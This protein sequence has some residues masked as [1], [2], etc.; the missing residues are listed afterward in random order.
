MLIL[1]FIPNLTH[2]LLGG[3][4]TVI[5][6]HSF[7]FFP[8]PTLADRCRWPRSL[9]SPVSYLFP[10]A[11][12]DRVTGSPTFL[13][14]PSNVNPPPSEYLQR[15]ISGIECRRLRRVEFFVTAPSFLRLIELSLDRFEPE[16]HKP[17][18]NT[19]NA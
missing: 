10:S 17:L 12:L 6:S 5:C 11:S 8:V 15:V 16:R 18:G 3:K 19:D 13:S 7:A 4:D 14:L 2:T 9:F 1:Q